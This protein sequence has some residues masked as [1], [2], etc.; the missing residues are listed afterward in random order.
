MG[1]GARGRGATC[2]AHN[3]RN[4]TWA[5]ENA[6]PTATD[7]LRGFGGF[8]AACRAPSPNRQLERNLFVFF[9]YLFVMDTVLDSRPRLLEAVFLGLC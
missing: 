9:L 8:V 6:R 2:L 3:R 7:S 1:R 4:T 5:S